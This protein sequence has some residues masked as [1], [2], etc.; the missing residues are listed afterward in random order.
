MITKTNKFDHDKENE[1]YDS[2]LSLA[3]SPQRPSSV[4]SINSRMTFASSLT[5]V[6][7]FKHST[8]P[9]TIEKFLE[10]ED[11]W[12]KSHKTMALLEDIPVSDDYDD[13]CD[14]ILRKDDHSPKLKSIE[15]FNVGLCEMVNNLRTFYFSDKYSFNL[16]VVGES[17]LGKTTPTLSSLSSSSIPIE[18]TMNICKR[19]FYLEENNVKLNLSIIDTP[20]FGEL[21]D[22]NNCWRMIMQYIDK[23]LYEYYRNEM[24]VK[25]NENF[26]DNRIHCCLYFIRPTGHQ[27]K[28]LD[29]IVLKKLCQRVNVIPVIGKSDTMTK[30]ELHEFK[31]IIRSQLKDDGIILYDFPNN[32][33]NDLKDRIP[34]SIIASNQIVVLPNDQIRRVREYPWG[35]VDIENEDYSDFLLLKNLLL[36]FHLKDLIDTTNDIHYENYRYRQLKSFVS[37][38]MTNDNI[39]RTE[40]NDNKELFPHQIPSPI[41]IINRS[42]NNIPLIFSEKIGPSESDVFDSI[43][44]LDIFDK[45]ER[46]YQFKLKEMEEDMEFIIKQKVEKKEIFLRMKEN[47]LKNAVCLQL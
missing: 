9:P 17:G 31:R 38:L 37:N 34:L 2:N 15:I 4:P 36:K 14:V 8:K 45:I 12:K 10:I 19:N 41:P 18:K 39:K 25:I 3:T 22:N 24:K 21:I 30:H 26:M 13:P 16:M 33:V 40:N 46:A 20:G 11:K 6:S 32:S 23:Q 7:T 1:L 28:L 27:M 29:R 44:L 47:D 5:K 43:S 42:S 35:I